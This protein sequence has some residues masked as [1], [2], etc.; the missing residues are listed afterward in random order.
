M[1]YLL[2]ALVVLPVIVLV[3]AALTGRANVRSCCSISDPANDLRMRGAFEES[4]RE[5]RGFPMGRPGQTGPV[6][7]SRRSPRGNPPS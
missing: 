3:I 6:V 2:A 5:S 4:A 1:T 7:R